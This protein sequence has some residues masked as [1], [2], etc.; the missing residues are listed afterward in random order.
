MNLYSFTPKPFI[1]LQK[2]SGEKQGIFTQVPDY[3]KMNEYI[4]LFYSYEQV[5]SDKIKNKYYYNN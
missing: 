4:G 2:K 5:N 1:K 3:K